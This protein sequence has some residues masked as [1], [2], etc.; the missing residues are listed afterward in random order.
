MTGTTIRAKIKEKGMTLKSV[1]DALGIPPQNLQM[2]L[3]PK[4]ISTSTLESIARAINMPVSYFYN[5]Y[6]ILRIEDYAEIEL[7]K[8]DNQ[9][10]QQRLAD[11]EQIINLLKK[12]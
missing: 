6:P 2:L 9:N 4:D 8:R 11:K 1:A 5:E 12:Q 3:R 10:L 7:L